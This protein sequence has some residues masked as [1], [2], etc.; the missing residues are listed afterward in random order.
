MNDVQ[1]NM[2][3]FSKKDLL[4]MYVS[5]NKN[6]EPTMDIQLLF[7]K[8]VH[9]Y[10]LINNLIKLV[11]TLKNKQF[12]NNLRLCRNCF[13]FSHSEEQHRVHAPC[14]SNNKEARRR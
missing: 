9:H 6:I 12:T 7:N 2:F 1:V 13:T 8:N 5:N 4:P 14:T 10:V 11:C 3:Q